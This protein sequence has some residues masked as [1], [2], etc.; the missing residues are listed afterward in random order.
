MIKKTP[1]FKATRLFNDNTFVSKNEFKKDI[2]LVNFF[3]TWCG[4][5]RDEHAY[6]KKLS[7]KEGIKVLGI[8]YKD[9]PIK[10]KNWLKELGNPYYKV[11]LDNK[12][13]IGIDWGVYGIPETFIVN[14]EGF[15]K[16]KFVGP[17]TKK[18]FNLIT[19]K[20]KEIENQ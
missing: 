19:D 17:V 12:G 1:E 8:N 4:P 20:I 10:T 7:Q 13:N 9:D 6:I 15:I 18:K 11:I 14:S 5:C 16:Y 3:A 2:T